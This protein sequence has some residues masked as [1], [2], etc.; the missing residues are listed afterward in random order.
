MKPVCHNVNSHTH[1]EPEHVTGPLPFRPRP[2]ATN[3]T[4]AWDMKHYLRMQMK[5]MCHDVNSHTHL[6]PEHVAGVEVTQHNE[7][8]HCS[9]TIC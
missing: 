1:L 4:S 2:P 3:S 5:P 7:Q 9:S 6:K 8:T